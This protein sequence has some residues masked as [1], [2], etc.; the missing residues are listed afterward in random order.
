MAR[1]FFLTASTDSDIIKA[2]LSKKVVNSLKPGLADSMLSDPTV[3]YSITTTFTVGND[4]VSAVA[5]R[6][7]VVR[8]FDP[9]V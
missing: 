3:S 5:V 2:K 8:Y 7:D 9:A 1:A 4:D 6:G